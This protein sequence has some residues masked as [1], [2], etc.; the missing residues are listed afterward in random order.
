M[1][2][3]VPKL[4]IVLYVPFIGHMAAHAQRGHKEEGYMQ[5]ITLKDSRFR[6]IG[7]IDIAPNG[8]K[9][10]RNEKFQILGYYKAKQDVTQDARFMTVGRGDILTS[11]LH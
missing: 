2:K 11:L 6:I 7:Y 9:T 8:D 4:L 3:Y 5:R 10:L 1:E